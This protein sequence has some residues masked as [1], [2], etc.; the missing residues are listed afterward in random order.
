M[1][2]SGGP[3]ESPTAL[4][5]CVVGGDVLLHG[6]GVVAILVHRAC[7]NSKWVGN[8]ATA[9]RLVL[10]GRRKGLASYNRL[11][12]LPKAAW[13]IVVGMKLAS[14]VFCGLIFDTSPGA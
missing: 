4:A 3:F 11:K 6:A 8:G 2:D 13:A 7:F 1:Q 5:K 14:F 9:H 12:R 10:A